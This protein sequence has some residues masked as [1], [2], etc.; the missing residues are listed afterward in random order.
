MTNILKMIFTHL[1][2]IEDTPIKD[3]TK[4]AYNII[5]SLVKDRLQF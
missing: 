5:Q 4:L 1:L 3:I 2:F